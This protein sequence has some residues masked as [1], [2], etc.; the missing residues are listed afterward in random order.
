MFAFKKLGL[1]LSLLI[2]ILT[3]VGCPSKYAVLISANQVSNDDI[4]YHSTWW[5]DLV[6]MYRTLLE[7]GFEEENIFVL[8][9]DGNDFPSSH[10]CYNA[11]T[12]FGHS[13]TDYP[14]SKTDIE[15]IF[16]WLSSGN[17]AE[18]ILPVDNDDFLFV[19]W[20]GHGEGEGSD[21]CDLTMDITNRGEEV[22]DVEFAGYLNGLSAFDKR[23]VLIMTCHSGGMLDNL[24]VAG[25]N[26]I[27]LTSSTCHENSH[28]G[29]GYDVNH[30]EF[31][32]ESSVALRTLVPI[33]T[34][35]CS[36]D[37][38]S[39][40]SD[41]NGNISVDECFSCVAANMTT[42]TPQM[43]DTDGLASTTEIVRD[44]P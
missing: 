18:G 31:N 13:I 29:S 4:A 41:G 6:L 8:Y 27:N 42:S 22:S 28:D 43:I 39:C 36:S 7:N 23:L 40:D 15:N 37:A 25:T 44:Q 21:Y 10:S 26:T 35:S 16:F 24:D 32:Y 17:A 12:Q 38:T 11:T 34:G 19:W 1:C 30:A 33:L 5:Y 9:A 20:M 2:V 3:F 14:N